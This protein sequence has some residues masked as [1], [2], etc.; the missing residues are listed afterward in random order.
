MLFDERREGGE[1][2]GGKEGGVRLQCLPWEISQVGSTVRSLTHDNLF[3]EI[4]ETG[5]EEMTGE[6][7]TGLSYA[8]L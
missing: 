2:E 1:R 3:N 7:T 8:T 5:E 4:S 6:G